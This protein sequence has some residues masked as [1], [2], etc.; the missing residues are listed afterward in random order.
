MGFVSAL[1]GLKPY[2]KPRGN[3]LLYALHELDIRDK[4]KLLIEA[5]SDVT[6]LYEEL[7]REVADWP[8]PRVKGN[9]N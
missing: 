1:F 6:I 8:F 5:K 7:L 2:K 3:D 4:H 9:N